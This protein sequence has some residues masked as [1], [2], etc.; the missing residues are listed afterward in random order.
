MRAAFCKAEIEQRF[1]Q[2]ALIMEKGRLGSFAAALGDAYIHAD[3]T[4][5]E[6]L[7]AAFPDVYA[8][9]LDP[10][11]PHLEIIK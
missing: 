2:A 10:I 4:N 8:A 9:A 1:L 7:A 6:R 3:P 5:R 11:T